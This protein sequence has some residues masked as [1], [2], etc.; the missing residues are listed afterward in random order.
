MSHSLLNKV[1]LNHL[2]T[3]EYPHEDVM[4]SCVVRD[5]GTGWY[6]IAEGRGRL[7]G[8][9]HIWDGT[10]GCH[11]FVELTAAASYGVFRIDI[12]M[13]GSWS[14]KSITHARWLYPTN[15]R[16]YGTAKLQ[17][18]LVDNTTHPEYSVEVKH[19]GMHGQ[20]ES[21]D[22]WE[23]IPIVIPK[24]GLPSGYSVDSVSPV[25]DVTRDKHVSNGLFTRFTITALAHLVGSDERIKENIE[26]IV[27]PVEKLNC[28]YCSYVNG[29]MQYASAIAGRTEL[30]FCPI[31]HA[32]KVAHEHN[33]YHTFLS[34]GEGEDYQKKLNELRE[35]SEEKI[36]ETIP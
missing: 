35:K 11:N 6:T 10:P 26:P 15:D 4:C 18:Y 2:H 23:N 12:G 32:K 25:Q 17:V 5:S 27:D 16:I 36:E 8:K 9:W 13:R 34:Y 7:F 14:H 30:Y 24:Q 3:G 22:N 19:I 20:Y 21:W 1:E 29:L 33:Y 28:L 31:K